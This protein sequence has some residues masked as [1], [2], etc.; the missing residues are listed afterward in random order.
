M[1]PPMLKV[2]LINGACKSQD[3]MSRT[4]EQLTKESTERINRQIDGYVSGELAD[5]LDNLIDE[6][7]KT[8]TERLARNIEV[9]M[10]CTVKE[11]GNYRYFSSYP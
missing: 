7:V 5:D 3:E 1:F 2:P 10:F 9:E 8:E 4:I 6:C 11:E